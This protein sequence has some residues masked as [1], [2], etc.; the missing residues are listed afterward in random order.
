MNSHPT[1]NWHPAAQH[2]PSGRRDFLQVGGLTALGLGLG[3]YCQQVHAEGTVSPAKSCILIWLDGGPSHLETLDPK[4]DATAEV[5]GPFQ[6]ISTS[7]PGIQISELMP[8]TAA[9]MQHTAIIRSMTSPLGEHNFGTHYLLTGYKPTPALNYPAIGSVVSHLNRRPG[10][11]PSHVALPDLRVGGGKFVASGYLPSRVSPFEVGGDPGSPNF[12]V[13][14]LDPFPGIVDER[15]GRRRDYLQMLNGVQEAA[16]ANPPNDAAFEQAYRLM[17]SPAA[18]RAFDLSAESDDMRR[19]YGGKSIGQC[20]LL[21]RRLVEAGVPFVT[22]NNRGWD[23]HNDLVTRLKEGYTGAK[24]PVGLVPSLDM[25]YAAL[26]TDLYERRLLDDTL[27]VVMGEFGRTPKLN[28]Q[29]GRDHWPR[30]FSVMMAGG[31]IPGGQLIGSSD[32]MGE[33]PASR[34]VTPAD[35]AATVY[36]LLGINPSTTLYTSDGRP[37]QVSADGIALSELVG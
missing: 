33:S 34:A 4:P 17:I 25:A 31:G 21:A 11:I 29:A 1:T 15:L 35:L 5:R 10:E 23:T 37:V 30:V 9:A 7:V 6:A 14:D 12:Q 22:V 18:K 16:H 20:C 13:R 36:R 2:A 32:A 27:V 28:T 19:R 8:R 26:V 3:S 24:V